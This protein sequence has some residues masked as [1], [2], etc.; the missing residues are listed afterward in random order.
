MITLGVQL[1]F[2]L[3]QRFFFNSK[4][5]IISSKINKLEYYLSNKLFSRVL[6]LLKKKVKKKR[7]FF[8]NV[9]GNTI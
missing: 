2:D 4:N 1:W 9:L 3:L 6:N 5:K 7:N 8:Q